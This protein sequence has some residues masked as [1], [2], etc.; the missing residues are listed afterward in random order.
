MVPRVRVLA[1][2][3]LLLVVLAGTA[4][5][6]AVYASSTPPANGRAPEGLQYVEVRFTEGVLREYTSIDVVDAA[7]ESVAV[8]PTQFDAGN[9]AVVRRAVQ[10]L[11]DGIYAV[12]WRALSVDTH[13]TRGSFLFSAGNATLKFAPPVTAQDPTAHPTQAIVKD[14]AARAGFFVGL[15]AALGMPLFGLVVDRE[16]PL[17]RHLLASAGAL[18]LAGALSAGVMLL[19]FAQRAELAL[20]AATRTDAGATIAWRGLLLAGAGA[21]L[22]VAAFAPGRA[23]RNLAALA[24]LVAGASLV[25]AALG[26]H[27]AAVQEQKGLTIAMDA[28]HLLMGAVWVGGV[29]A[30][31]LVAWGRPAAEVGRLVARFTPLAI[32]GVVVLAATGVY[33]SLVHVPRLSDLW[34]DRYGRLVLL[35]V[36][37][38]GPLV[39]LGWYNKN[40]VGPRLMAGD[41]G[42]PGAFRRALQA[43]AVV[44]LLVLSA[45]GIL[46]AS[47]PPDR[48]VAATD[49]PPALTFEA[50]NQTRTSH[51]ILQ[52]TP[53]P[54]RVGTQNVTVLVHSLAGALPNGTTLGLK[55][56]APD[57]PREPET[58]VEVHPVGPGEWTL[59]EGSHFTSPG[60]WRVYVLLQR[61]DEYRKLVFD[62]PVEA[63]GAPATT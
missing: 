59:G 9:E 12:S 40:R 29:A 15:F 20:D 46:A 43:E 1:L 7:G 25:A 36:A 35:K 3:A 2:S 5:A 14:G 47:P 53:N 49:A 34:T 11:G 19:L 31:L 17:P 61:P 50:T 18:G 4:S 28:A 22:L 45:A 52:V 39:A 63:L 58:L 16:R 55:I 38:L 41:A 13:T 6:H 42:T 24:V 54:P 48:D 56:Q 23:K 10:P 33:A 44:M 32:A 26:S 51:V 8:G 27:A 21:L 30:F 60:T 62:V 37:L 57:E